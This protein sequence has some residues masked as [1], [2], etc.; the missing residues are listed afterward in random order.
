[1]CELWNEAA[2]KKLLTESDL[3]LENAINISVTME[4]ASKEAQ[5]LNAT[6]RVHKLSSRT[7]SS[8]QSAQGPCFR[9]GKSGH[10][11]SACFCKDMDCH[12]CRKIGHVEWA[13]RK[14]RAWTKAQRLKIRDT[15]NTKRKDMFAQLSMAIGGIVVLQRKN[16]LLLQIQYR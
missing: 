14:E 4:M 11:D 2:Q 15:V 7:V 10:L 1:M 6:G 12:N 9:C 16:C 8:K 13:C 5:Q 3:T